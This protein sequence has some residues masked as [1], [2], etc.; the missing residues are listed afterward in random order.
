MSGVYSIRC[1]ATMLVLAVAIAS[2]NVSA[3]ATPDTADLL[4]VARLQVNSTVLYRSGEW[5]EVRA[6]GK[7]TG[8][9]RAS[10]SVSLF[11]CI[12]ES[13]Q[14]QSAAT[15]AQLPGTGVLERN[16]GPKYSRCC[17]PHRPSGRRS[18]RDSASQAQMGD[19]VG[20]PPLQWLGKHAVWFSCKH[21]SASNAC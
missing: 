12:L 21:A 4:G 17:S 5:F 6:S 13:C 16:A 15:G 14:S 18:K 10:I 7:S 8:S 11:S 3:S 20:E 1:H 19:R 2:S 9:D